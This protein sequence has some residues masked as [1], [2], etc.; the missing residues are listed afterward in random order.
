MARLHAATSR[1]GAGRESRELLRG[2]YSL[3]LESQL[4]LYAG[5]PRPGAHRN[6]R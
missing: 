2:P 3:S 1:R 5:A 4:V 6:G